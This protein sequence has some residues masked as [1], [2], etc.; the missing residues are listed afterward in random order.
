MKK[1]L[2]AAFAALAFATGS[3]VG[4]PCT[5]TSLSDYLTLGPCDLGGTGI[6]VDNFRLFTPLPTGTTPINPTAVTVNPL[7]SPAGL[8]FGLGQTAD[9]GELFGIRFGFSV[10]SAGLAGTT[11]ELLN[12]SATGDG[13]VTAIQ[14]LC[15][16]SLFV[17]D[18]GNGGTCAGSAP[19]P[20]IA[21]A[22]DGLSDPVQP[23]TF[24]VSS[25]FDVFVELSVDGGP[26][27]SAALGA[28]SLT[29]AGARAVPE[30]AGLGLAA[31]GLVALAAWTRRRRFPA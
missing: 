6:T 31:L 10:A 29:F 18:P 3:A 19:P 5:S 2:R 23:Q 16:G 20:V 4:A 15:L 24:P 26:S 25:F 17:G 11:L 22:I 12:A 8:F 14:G 28:F 21:F 13:V 9:A 1:T 30:P 7:L 27:G